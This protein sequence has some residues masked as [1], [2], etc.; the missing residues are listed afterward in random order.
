M[1][2]TKISFLNLILLTLILYICTIAITHFASTRNLIVSITFGYCLSLLY[3]VSGYLSIS[4]AFKKKQNLFLAVIFGSIAIR[5]I[6]FAFVLFYVIKHT[7]YSVAGFL[8]S[9]F[10]FY[11]FLQVQEIRFINSELKGHKSNASNDREELDG[12]A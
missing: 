8:L 9:F 7:Q 6:L 12:G 1:K 4:R 10:L 5:F 11:F 3:I 2:K